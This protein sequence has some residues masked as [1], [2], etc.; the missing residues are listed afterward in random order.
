MEGGGEGGCSQSH[1]DSFKV[2]FTTV[3]LPHENHLS[4][5][6]QGKMVETHPKSLEELL[7]WPFAHESYLMYVQNKG[8]CHFW[9]MSIS[10]ALITTKYVLVFLKMFDAPLSL[11]SQSN[12]LVY[13]KSKS[14]LKSNDWLKSEGSVCHPQG[15]PVYSLVLQPLKYK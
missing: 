14:I 10:N 7:F 13:P 6:K 5:L 3:K 1:Y 2:V 15:N 9:T 8:G 4:F 11:S 12:V